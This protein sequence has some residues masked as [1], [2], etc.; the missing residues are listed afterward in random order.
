M[1]VRALGAGHSGLKEVHRIVEFLSTS[2]DDAALLP[3]GFDELWQ[4]VWSVYQQLNPEG[5]D[6]QR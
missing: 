5:T 4:A 2:G 6:D 1:M 3:E